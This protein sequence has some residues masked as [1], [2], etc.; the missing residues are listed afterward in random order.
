VNTPDEFNASNGYDELVDDLSIG[1]E[2]RDLSA[3]ELSM[4]ERRFAALSLEWNPGQIEPDQGRFQRAAENAV[5]FGKAVGALTIPLIV[6]AAKASAKAFRASVIGMRRALDRSGAYDLHQTEQLLAQA[7]GDGSGTFTNQSL[8]H[9]LA[10]D[11]KIPQNFA[12]ILQQSANISQAI[13]DRVVVQSNVAMG[14]IAKELPDDAQMTLV[15]YDEALKKVAKILADQP[16]LEAQLSSAETQFIWP[17]G[18]A[19]TFTPKATQLKDV[20]AADDKPSKDLVLRLA[21]AREDIAIRPKAGRQVAT[22]T[23][24]VLNR[25]QAQEII[26]A[27]VQLINFNKGL[28]NVAEGKQQAKFNPDL[29]PGTYT[30]MIGA[31]ASSLRKLAG[32]PEATAARD[33]IV[34]AYLKHFQ[35]LNGRKVITALF[36]RNLSTI[37]AALAYVRASVKHYN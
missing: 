1:L 16:R 5:Q 23:L 36:N 31:R 18:A 26:A 24:E 27:C 6:K 20:D 29:V 32:I 22:A 7:A 11:G 10:L 9:S 8:A 2:G 4:M 21:N 12:A 37:R 25:Q 35:Y 34:T 3:D 17:G 30:A 14:K 33:R 28:L 13:V 19:M 15:E